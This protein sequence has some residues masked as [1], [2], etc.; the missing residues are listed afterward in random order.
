MLQVPGVARLVG[1]DGTPAALPEDEIE[2]LRTSLGNRLR[3]EPYPYLAAGRRVRVQ[4]GPLAGLTGVLVRRKS[5][6]R[7]VVSVDL[8]QRSWAVEVDE[9]D[10]VALR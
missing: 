7:F 6:A 4:S 9:A 1:F 10:L 2:A 5:R 8:I 3:V